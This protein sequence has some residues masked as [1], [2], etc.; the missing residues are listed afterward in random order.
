M[1]GDAASFVAT[2][3]GAGAFAAG[4][5]QC[6][7][8]AIRIPARPDSTEFLTLQATAASATPEL[9]PADNTAVYRN[10]IVGVP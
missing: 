3:R 4:A 6:F 10:R 9:A 1:G 7:D 5:S 8:V 2:C